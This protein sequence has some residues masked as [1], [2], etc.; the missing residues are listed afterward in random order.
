LE[1]YIIKHKPKELRLSRRD[2]VLLGR[3]G[4][5]ALMLSSALGC[6]QSD[7]TSKTVT[8]NKEKSNS[9]YTLMFFTTE[10]AAIV[11]AVSARIIPSDRQPG[12]REAKV[13]Y[14]ID[15]MLADAYKTAQPVY[16]EGISKL[17]GVSQTRFRRPFISISEADQDD[18]LTRME[19]RTLQQ[20]ER[21]GEFFSII[22]AHTIEGMFSDPRYHGNSNQIGWM[23]L[24]ETH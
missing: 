7:P 15:Y 11:E 3:D 5:T 14:F 18:I 4:I 9:E 13:V 1:R 12:A 21:A 20:W 10:E 2:F 22:R 6:R 17:N 19:Q 16:R 8:A 23:L 24:G